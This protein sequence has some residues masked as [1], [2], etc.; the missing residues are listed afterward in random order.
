MGDLRSA[1]D[2]IIWSILAYVL[3]N[4]VAGIIID[5]SRKRKRKHDR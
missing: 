2:L 4:M 5:T 3:A 1:L